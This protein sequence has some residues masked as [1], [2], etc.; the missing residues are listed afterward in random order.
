M[1]KLIFSPILWF[2]IGLLV[3]AVFAA[4]APMERTLGA[5]ARLIYF[6]GAWVWVAMVA[7]LLA[8]GT[9]L[10]G[11]VTRNRHYQR[12][13]L[14]LGRTGLFFWVIFLPMSL[15]VMQL[16]WNGLFL[17]E[18]RFRIPLNF[19][20]VGLL[21]QG[22]LALWVD[23]RATSL[24][25]VAYGLALWVSMYNVEAVMHPES[26]IFNSGSTAIQLFFIGALLALCFTGW[27][28]T[29]LWLLTSPP[30]R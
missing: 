4:T 7:F 8:A 17:D 28:F 16:N 21:L 20:I 3:S 27:Q 13:S 26:P 24:A 12:W 10:A 30:D 2:P 29:R 5:N 9:G 19:A 23:L 6:H 14:A 15:L 1:R 18:P 11:L 25:N 22:G